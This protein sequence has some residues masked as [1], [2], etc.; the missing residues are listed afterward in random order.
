MM[1]HGG[2]G[3]PMLQLRDLAVRSDFQIGPLRISPSRR[4]VEGPAGQ[5]HLEPLIM[6]VFLLLLEAD[7]RVVTR[8]D[9]FDQCWGGVYVGDDSLNRAIA[10]V[11]RIASDVAPG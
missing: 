7:G 3:L 11:R 5:L 10:K 8:S 6:Q 4:L 9:L 2:R 1:I